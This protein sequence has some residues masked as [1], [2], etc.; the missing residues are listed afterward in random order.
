MTPITVEQKNHRCH[1]YDVSGRRE[2]RYTLIA[3]GVGMSM[4]CRG[5][6]H[7][8]YKH[9]KCGGKMTLGGPPGGVLEAPKV[10]SPPKVIKIFWG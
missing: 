6:K 10:P 9:R 8:Y 3:T 4:V 5:P 1:N 2:A 7:P